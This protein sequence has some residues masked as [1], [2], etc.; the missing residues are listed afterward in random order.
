MAV[1]IVPNAEVLTPGAGGFVLNP[2]PTVPLYQTT[3]RLGPNPMLYET[4]S[5]SMTIT[6]QGTGT[7][8]APPL[9]ELITSVSL[10][11]GQGTGGVGAGCSIVKLIDLA[12]EQGLSVTDIPQYLM[13]GGFLEPSMVYGTIFGPPAPTMALVAPLKGFY[14]EKY[15][16]DAEYIYCLL[17]TSPS[18][19]DQRGSRMPSSA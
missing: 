1:V 17:Y 8:F 10:I 15:F 19:R 7:C 12:L 3:P 6:V 5:P 16:Y 18:P 13:T 4:I 2:L 14:G 11:P 9:P